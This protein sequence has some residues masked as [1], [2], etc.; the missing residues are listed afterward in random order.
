MSRRKTRGKIPQKVVD[1]LMFRNRHRCCVCREPEKHV[2]I[3]HIDGDSSNNAMGNL[4]VLCLG[5][6]SRAT[7]DEGLGRRYSPGE[8]RKYKREWEGLNTGKLAK[9]NAVAEKVAEELFRAEIAKLM[10]QAIALK[11]VQSQLEALDQMETYYI[12][13]G[14]REAILDAIH[15]DGEC[16]GREEID[17]G[18]CRDPPS[19]ILGSSGA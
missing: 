17:S 11:D 13:L 8:V 16:L 10:V 4:A 18:V 19:S 14:Q 5:C 1:E 3:H 15:S 12:Y 2:Q 7:S 9:P 6:H